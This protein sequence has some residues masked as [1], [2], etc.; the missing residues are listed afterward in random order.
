MPVL[1]SINIGILH[2]VLHD[3]VSEVRNK[4]IAWYKVTKDQEEQYRKAQ[5]CILNN[6]EY[7]EVDQCTV[8]N[9]CNTNHRNQ[10]DRWCEQLVHCCLNANKFL[11]HVKMKKSNKPYWRQEVQPYKF[12][13]IWWHNIWKECGERHDGVIYQSKTEAHRPYMYATRRYK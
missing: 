6:L 13:S 1:I 7:P 5:G 10:I 3:N 12:N 11:S 9:C 8:V 2:R 4:P